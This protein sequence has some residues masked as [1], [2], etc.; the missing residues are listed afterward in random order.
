MEQ[1]LMDTNVVS[2]YLSGSFFAA[3]MAF[4]DK[5]IDATPNLSIITQKNYYAGKRIMLQ[6]YMYKIL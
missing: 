1:Y 3:G 5:I 2:D 6:N 4:M